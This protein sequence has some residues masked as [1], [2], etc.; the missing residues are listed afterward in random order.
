MLFLLLLASEF[1]CALSQG[2]GEELRDARVV[3]TLVRCSWRKQGKAARGQKRRVCAFRFLVLR[4]DDKGD[5][6]EGPMRRGGGEGGGFMAIEK[7]KC[8]SKNNGE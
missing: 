2:R 5:N 6:V 7:T 8:Y 1:D 3:G 4:E